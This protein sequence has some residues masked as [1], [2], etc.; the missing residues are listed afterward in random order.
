MNSIVELFGVPAG[1]KDIDWGRI[2]SE[3]YCIFSR[4]QC[5][6]IRKSNPKI[7]IGTCV[8]FH[9]KAKEPIIICPAR[10]LEHGKIFTDCFHLLTM[11]EPGNALHI[12]PEVSIPGGSVD[13]FLVS[14]KND[15]VMDFVGIELQTLDTTGTIWPERQQLLKEFGISQ[16]DDTATTSK[17]FG[18]NWKMT[19]KTIL[20]QMHHKVKT[21][22]CI[23]K[24][25]VLIVQ[26]SLFAYMAKE[27][28]FSHLHNPSLLGDSMHMH[29]YGMTHSSQLIHTLSMQSRVSTDADGVGRCL[30]LRADAHIDLETIIA[31]LQS[32]IASSTLFR[33]V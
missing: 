23:N 21:F 24:K 3:Q 16:I 4:K 2:V 1:K 17:P 7:A 29:I 18:M 27:F 8:V 32:K 10:L 28:Q 33:P 14:T 25:I 15:K 11:H 26:D 9:G 13:Y 22:E 19:A 30:G 6:K 31:V 5:Y 12:I 20:I